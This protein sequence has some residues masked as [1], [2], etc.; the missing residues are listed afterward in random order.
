MCEVPGGHAGGVPP[1][2]IP[3]TE[4]KPSRAH[5]TAAARLWESRTLPGYNKGPLV[6]TSGPFLFRAGNCD[7]RLVDP[8]VLAELEELEGRPCRSFAPGARTIRMCSL[9]GRSWTN[10]GTL[11]MDIWKRRQ[12]DARSRGSTRPPLKGTIQLCPWQSSLRALAQL[13][14]GNKIPAL[15]RSSGHLYPHGGLKGKNG[16]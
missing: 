14:Q 11:P 9:D 12:K 13:P 2:P 10:T 16:W 5:D 15:V 1:V 8:P 7:G 6:G 4:V 3:N